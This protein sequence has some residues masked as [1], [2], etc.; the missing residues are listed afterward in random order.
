MLTIRNESNADYG[1]VEALIRKAFY[2][3]YTPGCVEHY[4]VR[5]MRKHRDFIPELDL[6]AELDG[7]IIGS[8]MY[9]RASLTSEA[10]EAKEI[11]TFGPICIAPDHQ[12]S[13]YGKQLMEYSFERALKLGYDAIVIFGNPA[14][15]VGSGFKSC[16]KYNVLSG[17]GRYPAAMLV[18]ELVPGALAGKRW[19]YHGSSVMDISEEDARRYDDTLEE[20]EKVYRPSQDEF[21]IMSHAFID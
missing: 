18:K 13:G 9:T 4:L 1:T 2:N 16:K 11:L 21:F 5:I 12:R 7:Q 14:N 19:F 8:I 10:G 17:E 15:Y 6:V 3:I 20:M